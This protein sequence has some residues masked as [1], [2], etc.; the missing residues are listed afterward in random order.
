[1]KHSISKKL[2]VSV[3]FLSV[4]LVLGIYCAADNEV[5]GG[6]TKDPGPGDNDFDTV[7]NGIDNCINVANLEQGDIDSDG[8]GDL[9]DTEADG[10]G[11]AN[12]ADNCPYVANAE[13]ANAD[14]DNYGDDCDPC[15]NTELCDPVL[16][17]TAPITV[18]PEESV[19]YVGNNANDRPEDPENPEPENLRIFTFY[20]KDDAIFTVDT[21]KDGIPDAYDTDDK[22]DFYLKWTPMDMVGE[23][24]FYGNWEYTGRQLSITTT[25]WYIMRSTEMIMTGTEDFAL[26]YTYEN[27]KYLDLY[28]PAQGSPGDGSTI[29]GTSTQLISET[30]QDMGAMVHATI[31]QTFDVTV[32]ADMT[33]TWNVNRKI[34]CPPSFLACGMMQ[35]L[36]EPYEEHRGIWDASDDWKLYELDW[37]GGDTGYVFQ[38]NTVDIM[39]RQ[40]ATTD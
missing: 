21:S 1:M 32:D 24:E 6:L 28:N 29:I 11:I 36:T 5:I 35:D 16:M 3:L 14:G 23:T 39:V 26:A 34:V 8:I 38:A 27:G 22:K 12:D 17:P 25:A 20:G 2:T 37:G 30:T 10:D 7:S 15:V 13:Q 33:W 9:C 40:D 18:A 4:V 31:T 19:T